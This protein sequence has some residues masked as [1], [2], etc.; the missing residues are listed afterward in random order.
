MKKRKQTALD[1]EIDKLINSIENALTGEVFDTVITLLSRSDTKKI[2]KTD[3]VFNWHGEL[4][5]EEKEIY[6]LTTENNPSIIHGGKYFY[7]YDNF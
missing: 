2:R 3:W 5:N 6:E 4:K 1:L 7:S